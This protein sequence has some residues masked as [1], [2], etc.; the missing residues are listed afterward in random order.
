MGCCFSSP[1][2]DETVSQHASR[3]VADERQPGSTPHPTHPTP[4]SNILPAS[5]IAYRRSTNQYAL[6]EHFNAPIRRHVWYSKRRLWSR[7][8]LDQERKDFFE[9]RVA[10]RP[11]VWAALSTA[12]ALMRANDLATAQ[13][14]I[15]A[16]GITVP[17]GDPC[18]GCYDEQGVLYR[19]PQCIVSDPE[20]MVRSR[21]DGE[22]D[23]VDDDDDDFDTEDGK[24]SADEASGDE[25]ITEELER[26]RDEKGK[27][28]ERDLI[29]VKA[30]LSDRGGPDV[31]V[32]VGNAQNVGFIAR[33]VQQEARIPR[34]H[35]VRIAYLGKM[36]KE[37]STL[38]E[39]GWTPD[40]VVNAL[41]TIRH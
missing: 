3:V 20:N 35:R 11:E 22:V 32:A 4:S 13:G 2:R 12:L 9:T 29:C 30:R 37:N 28:R 34:S 27:T 14:I 25:L 15:D 24:L 19:L 18:Q 17:T 23:G 36:L 33:K 21:S 8:T 38:V 5:T 1:R 40:H 39:Q 10:G 26:R 41:V 6:S 31:I 16:A 7:A